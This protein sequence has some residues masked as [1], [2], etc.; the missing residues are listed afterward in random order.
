MMNLIAGV[1][2]HD[3]DVV[4][5]G[6]FSPLSTLDHLVLEIELLAGNVA[7]VLFVLTR[8]ATISLLGS[9][10]NSLCL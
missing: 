2:W 9:C 5:M 8:L 4:A 1:L 6:T 3:Q 10:S 7:F